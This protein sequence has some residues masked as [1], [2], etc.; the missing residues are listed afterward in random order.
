MFMHMRVKSNGVAAPGTAV[1]QIHV[2]TYQAVDAAAV[3]GELGGG[4]LQGAAGLAV[5]LVVDA[6]VLFICF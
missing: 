6:E 5:L 2:R 3:V 4:V 1:H